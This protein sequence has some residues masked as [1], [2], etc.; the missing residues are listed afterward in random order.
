MNDD[1]IVNLLVLKM[2][3]YS[4]AWPPSPGLLEKDQG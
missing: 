4:I 3:K 1:L 2:E